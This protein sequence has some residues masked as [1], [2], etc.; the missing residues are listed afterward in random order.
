MNKRVRYFAVMLVLMAVATGYFQREP[1]RPGLRLALAVTRP[2][3][4]PPLPTAR[5]LLDRSNELTLTERQQA[6][7]Q[8]L[9]HQ[10]KTESSGL[11]TAIRK[12]QEVFSTFM[13]E[14][15]AGGKASVQEILNR[16]ADV[17]ILSETLR[18]RRQQHAGTVLEL[19]TESQRRILS[20]LAA[21]VRHGG[22]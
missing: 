20:G 13:R 10:W 8:A 12:E 3:V 9:D 11:E 1:A 18:E 5:L 6:R 2:V 21:S 4:S 17:R 22:A 7:L 19:L 15:Q 14:A 16:S